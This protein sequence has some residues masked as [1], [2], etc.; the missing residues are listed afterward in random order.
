MNV[1]FLLVF[2]SLVLVACSIWA[3]VWTVQHKDLDHADRLALAPLRDESA[4][5]APRSP[6]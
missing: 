1:L 6:S 2:V 3:F 4:G 5:L